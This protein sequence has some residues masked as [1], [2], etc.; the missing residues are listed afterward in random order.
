MKANGFPSDMGLRVGLHLGPDYAAH[1]PI[2]DRNNFFGAHVSRTAR[3]EPV[4]PEGCVYVTE[5]MAAGVG[6]A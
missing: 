1:D 3:I 2:L 4:T 5:T 6:V